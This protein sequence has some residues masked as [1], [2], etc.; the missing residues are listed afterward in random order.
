MREVPDVTL[1][2]SDCDSPTGTSV[3]KNGANGGYWVY[4]Q[5]TWQDGWGGTSFAAPEW[6]A[7]LGLVQQ[8]DGSTAIASPLVR[9]YAL[10][11][12][13]SYHTY[14]HDITSGCNSYDGVTGFCAAAGYDEGSGLGSFNGVALEAAY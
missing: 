3:C 12:G 11:G 14:F 13:A 9:L 10:A 2:A 1:M 8:K 7:F 4:F 5:G 6:G